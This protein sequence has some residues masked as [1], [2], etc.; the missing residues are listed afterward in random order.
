M[1]RVA[2]QG[3][4]GRKGPFAG[5]F[6]ALAIAAALVM[7]C[8]TLLEAGLRSESPVERYAGAPIVVAGDQ[9][10]EV[11]A[12]TEGQD[13]VPLFE[14]A[15]VPAALAS[16]IE[17]V[18]GPGGHDTFAHG[19]SRGASWPGSLRSAGSSP[20][21]PRAPHRAASPPR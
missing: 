6:V 15:R 18:P 17:A 3:L 16:R 1:L 14:R 2:L 20:P 5:A 19:W 13:R 21:Q 11:N 12:G 9:T 4:R 7:A 8:A 10:A